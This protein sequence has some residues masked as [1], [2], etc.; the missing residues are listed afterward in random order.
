M[1]KHVLTPPRK[2][3]WT[4]VGDA[5]NTTVWTLQTVPEGT[6]LTAVLEVQFKGLS[7]ALAACCRVAN[8]SSPSRMDGRLRKTR[9]GEVDNRFAKPT[10]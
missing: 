6:M 7:Q 10:T 8:E 3:R 4:A 1:E 5:I 2:S 9:R